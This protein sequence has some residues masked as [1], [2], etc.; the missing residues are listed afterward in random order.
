MRSFAIV[1][2]V[3]EIGCGVAFAAQSALRNMASGPPPKRFDKDGD[4]KISD[5]ERAAI[6]E[7]VRKRAQ[8][9]GAMTPSGK[10]ETIGNREVT[11]LEYTS[12]DGR[13]IPCVLSMPKGDGPFPCI[14]TIH[15]GPGNRDLAYLRT[16]AAPNSVSATVNAFNEQPWAVLAISYRAGALFGKEQD[17]VIAGIRFA[18]SLPKVDPARVGVMG[19]SHGGHLALIAAIRMG[20]EFA[21]V[22]AGS[23]WMTNPEVLLFPKPDEP[24]LSLLP[25]KVRTVL[26]DHGKRLYWGLTRGRGMSDQEVREFI[27]QQSIEFNADKIVI[28]SLFI[29]SLADQSVPHVMVEPTINRLKASGRDVMVFTAKNSPHGFYWGRDVGGSRILGG[30]KTPEE[31]A[32]ETQAREHILNFFRRCFGERK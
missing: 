8:R 5:N 19:G 13:K 30:M 21:C 28:P 24:P 10:T 20:N 2:L 18:K 9:P 31:L 27:R 4:G 16:L 11:E 1:L 32:E 12:S 22:V 25:E 23:P 6:R 14:V 15:G 26:M 17:D 29:T 3:L 7:L